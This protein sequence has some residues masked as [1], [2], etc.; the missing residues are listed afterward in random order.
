MLISDCNAIKLSGFIYTPTLIM[1][2]TG[3]YRELDNYHWMSPEVVISNDYGKASDIWS[4]GCTIIEM[5]TAKPPWLELSI[6]E[7]V[8]KIM[9]KTLPYN[10]LNLLKPFE[11][12]TEILAY[13]LMWD[14]KER[15]SAEYL[16][17]L[18]FCQCSVIYF[19]NY[20]YKS[21]FVYKF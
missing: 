1:N 7:F 19:C 14:Y 15:Q 21:A 8:C 11:E 20:V 10:K 13:C 12:A 6:N 5:I 2:E 9:D 16:L 17:N 3:Y 18:E 4:V